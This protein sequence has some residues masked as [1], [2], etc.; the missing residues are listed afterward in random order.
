MLGSGKLDRMGRGVPHERPQGKCFNRPH[1][2]CGKKLVD[3]MLFVQAG[4]NLAIWLHFR[5]ELS[6]V[7]GNSRFRLDADECLPLG[8]AQQRIH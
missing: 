3:P 4:S 5:A 1:G 6:S 2:Q 8:T 7:F